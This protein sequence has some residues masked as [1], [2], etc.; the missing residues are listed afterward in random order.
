V[1]QRQFISTRKISLE[2]KG[3]RNEKNQ[4]ETVSSDSELNK[5]KL[6]LIFFLAILKIEEREE[7]INKRDDTTDKHDPVN[8]ARKSPFFLIFLFLLPLVPLF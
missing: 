2:N 3:R 5:K 7:K 8:G 6:L 4:N 1:R